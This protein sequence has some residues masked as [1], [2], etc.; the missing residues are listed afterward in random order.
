MDDFLARIFAHEWQVVLFM[1]VLLVTLA[2]AGFRFGLRLHA[3]CPSL[4]RGAK[5]S[6]GK[7]NRCDFYI[8]NL[9]LGIPVHSGRREKS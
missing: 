9:Y 5:G 2:E 8:S 6:R 7:N 1:T 4:M 3:A